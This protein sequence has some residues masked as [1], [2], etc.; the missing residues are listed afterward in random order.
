MAPGVSSAQF[1]FPTGVDSELDRVV[2]VLVR[3][4]TALRHSILSSV[5]KTTPGSVLNIAAERCFRSLWFD[6]PAATPCPVY[7]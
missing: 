2:D 1:E 4:P 7:G 3:M 6:A 5:Q